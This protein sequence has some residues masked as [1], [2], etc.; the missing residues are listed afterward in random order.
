MLRIGLA[1]LLVVS[2]ACG[3]DDDEPPAP[4]EFAPELAFEFTIRGGDEPFDLNGD[5]DAAERTTAA[6]PDG[7]TLPGARYRVPGYR[8]LRADGTDWNALPEAAAS[9][10]E[11]AMFEVLYPPDG[12]EPRGLVFMPHGDGFEFIEAIAL[13]IYKAYP[14]TAEQYDVNPDHGTRGVEQSTRW[15]ATRNVVS[16]S[17]GINAVVLAQ[18][19]ATVVLPGNC[20]GDGGHGAG[21]SIDGY[22][23][24]PRLGGWFDHAAWTWARENLDHDASKAIAFAC[25]GGGHRTAEEL[26]RDDQAFAAIVLDSPA[27]N[28]AGFLIDPWPEL[29]GFA[30]TLLREPLFNEITEDFYRVFGGRDAAAQVSLG[31]RLPDLAVAAPIYLAYSTGDPAVTVPVVTDLVDAVSARGAPSTVVELDI[32]NHCQLQDATRL[33]AAT[34]W[35]TEVVDF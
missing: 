4:P 13:E 29:L 11:A 22:Y 5:L 30:Y 35:L 27:D 19:G 10:G 23:D 1:L 2:A 9:E 8:C 28:T 31:A 15:G 3:E 18:M 7:V 14:D 17:L 21:E 12:V 16:T 6:L 32:E 20:W 26:I 34:D 33:T 25:S 24:G